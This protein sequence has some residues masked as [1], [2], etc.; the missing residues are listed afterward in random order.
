MVVF[1]TIIINVSDDIDFNLSVDDDVIPERTMDVEAICRLHSVRMTP[2]ACVHI[3]LAFADWV[4]LY[5]FLISVTQK[6]ASSK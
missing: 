4:F 5:K 3:N 1:A 2:G 6:T